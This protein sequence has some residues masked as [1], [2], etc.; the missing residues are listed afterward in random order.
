MTKLR[1]LDLFSGIGGFS[2]GLER[3]GGFETVAFC[4]IEPFPRRVLA[5]HWPGVPCYEDVTTANFASVG[6][7][8]V[9]TGGFPCQDI[10]LAGPGAGL[11]G[12][13]SGLFWHILRAVRMVGHPML[14]LENVA[15]LLDRGMGSVLGALAQIGYDT[16]WH[17]IPAGAIGARHERDRVWITAHSDEARHAG[18]MQAGTDFAN[19]GDIIARLGP[20]QLDEVTFP[21]ND[22]DASPVVGGGSHGIPHR[23][24]RI[25]AIGNSVVPQIPELIGH[26][27]LAA[28]REREAA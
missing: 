5:K 16:Q 11:A 25:A 6:P 10:S 22:W 21:R 1:V 13:R 14:L 20:S 9:V 15:A 19:A 2:L 17:C 12:N 18:R 4:E 28:L 7:V 24:D 27:I 26:A 3:T 8:D 23:L